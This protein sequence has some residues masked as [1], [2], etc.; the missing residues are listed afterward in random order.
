MLRQS[1]Y[2]NNIVEQGHRAIK[3]VTGVLIATDLAQILRLV[4]LLR[5]NLISRRPQLRQTNTGNSEMTL[6]NLH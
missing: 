1:K 2:L 5:Q 3:R 6:S 4:V